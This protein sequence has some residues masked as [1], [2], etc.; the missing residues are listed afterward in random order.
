MPQAISYLGE[1]KDYS[2]Q[3]L[4]NALRKRFKVRVCTPTNFLH[5]SSKHS[6]IINRLYGSAVSR[7]STKKMKEI[8]KFLKIYIQPLRT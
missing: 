2:D 8:L 3:W 1:T 7:C 6:L 4:I 5:L